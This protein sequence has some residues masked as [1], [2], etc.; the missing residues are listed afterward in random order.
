VSGIFGGRFFIAPGGSSG[1]L[2]F[3]PATAFTKFRF[4]YPKTSGLNSAVG[5]YVDGVLVDT[6]NQN[7]SSALASSVYTVS[8]STHTIEIGVGS[9]GSGYVS[10]IETFNGSATPV[11]LQ[12]GFCALRAV[13]L[14]N[15]ST[16]WSSNPETVALAPDFTIIYCTI[17]DAAGGTAG[18]TYYA[19][20]EALIAAIAATS[21]GCL[22]VGFPYNGA[23]ATD[24]T[25][26][27]YAQLLINLA[28]DYSWSYYDLRGVLGNSYTK[29]SALSYNYND[30]HPNSAGATAAA[31]ALYN[32]LLSGGL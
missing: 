17:N 6:I 12:G 24:G 15:S 4:W 11:M 20:L 22:C 21:N 9:T 14:A 16:L 10:G 3:I 13:D 25:Y 23:G 30:L 19:N 31:T 2:K 1:K 28:A 26:D 8:N 27:K 7:A 29:A 5:V 32:F 18:N